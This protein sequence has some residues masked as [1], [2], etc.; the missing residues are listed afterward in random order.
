MKPKKLLAAILITILVVSVMTVTGYSAAQ[1]ALYVSPAG[2]DAAAGTMEAP[3]AT[4]AGAKERA[5]TLSGPVT[6]Y[7]RAGSYT[8]ERTVAFT[9]AD[10]AD[11]TYKAYGDER[12]VFTAGTPYTGFEETAVNGVRAFRKNVGH[13]DFNVLFGA[14]RALTRP[15][16]PETGCFTVKAV[17]AADVE[18]PQENKIFYGYRGMYVNQ[19]DVPALR[20]QAAF[21]TF[22]PVAFCFI[23]NRISHLPAL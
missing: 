18:D 6:V 23:F 4:L 21:L 9:A 10:K 13:A 7:F 14:E 19:S 16:L 22:R 12:V 2:N 17:S 11:V 1:T 8:F 3:L 5:K 15:R 20:N